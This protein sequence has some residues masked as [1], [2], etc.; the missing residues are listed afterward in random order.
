MHFSRRQLLALAILFGAAGIIVLALGGKRN[1][2]H[3]NGKS[4][5]YWFRGLPMTK[6]QLRAGGL[7]RVIQVQS[8]K[9]NGHDFGST[10][11]GETHASLQAIEAIGTN[12]IPFLLKKLAATDS[13]VQVWSDSVWS[14]F[15]LTWRPWRSSSMERGQAIVG[16]LRRDFWPFWALEE[17]SK[18]TNANNAEVA[19]ASKFVLTSALKGYRGHW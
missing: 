12:S 13:R 17:L 6:I 4:L 1:E 18:M 3:Y 14:E 5:S 2:A 16:L 7:H 9:S 8:A 10:N 15:K 11:R 19:M